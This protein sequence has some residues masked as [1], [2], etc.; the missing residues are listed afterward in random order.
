[1][2]EKGNLVVAMWQ[3]GARTTRTGR[4]WHAGAWEA[5]DTRKSTR[6]HAGAQRAEKKDNCRWNALLCYLL[7]LLQLL[8]AAAAGGIR[9]VL[10]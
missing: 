1:M 3:G 7:L 10:M 8:L 5:Q 9:Q 2:K 6:T 4:V